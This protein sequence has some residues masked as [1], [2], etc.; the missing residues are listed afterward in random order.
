MLIFGHAKQNFAIDY[1]QLIT[2]C[3]FVQVY[4]YYVSAI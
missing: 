2:V 3:A 1:M 4:F